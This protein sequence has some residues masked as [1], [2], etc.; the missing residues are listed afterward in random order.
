MPSRPKSRRP[1][2]IWDIDLGDTKLCDRLLKPGT[3]EAGSADPLCVVIVVVLEGTTC[4]LCAGA[5]AETVAAGEAVVI[6]KGAEVKMRSPRW[7][8]ALLIELVPPR[9]DFAPPETII[10]REVG[11][12][13]EQLARIG[14]NA[15]TIAALLDDQASTIFDDAVR[16]TIAANVEAALDAHAK[17]FEARAA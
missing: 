3:F 12:R 8:R 14:R 1:G 5:R 9:D 7:T 6:A 13:L 4:L 11:D 16:Q 10:L 15:K 2:R 17:A